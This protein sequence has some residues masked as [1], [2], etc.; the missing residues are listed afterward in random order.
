VKLIE[1]LQ[2]FSLCKEIELFGETLI[3]LPEEIAAISYSKFGFYNMPP[4]L[5]QIQPSG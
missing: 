5:L 2:R 3:R 4:S 1:K